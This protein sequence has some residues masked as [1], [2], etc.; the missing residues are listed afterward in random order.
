MNA[1]FV[2]AIA[3]INSGYSAFITGR[4]GTGKTTFI[5][6]IRENCRDRNFAVVA[7]TGIA[8]LNA[9][10]Q[11]IHSFFRLPFG[12]VDARDINVDPYRE[13]LYKRLDLL[14]IDEVSMVRADIL[15]GIDYVLRRSRKRKDVLFGGVQVI[16]VGDLFQLPPV[17]EQSLIKYFDISYGGPYFFMASCYQKFGGVQ[18]IEL[19]KIYRQSDSKFI[20]LLGR[21]CKNSMSDADLDIVNSRVIQL[22]SKEV[23]SDYIVL[24]TTN[25]I[26]EEVNQRFLRELKT[27]EFKYIAQVMG[28]FD[29]GSYPTD[30]DLI[31][32]QGAKVMFIRND[33]ERRWVNGTIGRISNLVDNRVF[34]VIGDTEHEV[35]KETWNKIDYDISYDKSKPGLAQ[36]VKG[37]FTQYPLRLAWAV[38]I[39]KG[40][41]KTFD[42]I[43]I[44][45]GNGMFAHGQAYVALSRARSLSGVVLKS[46]LRRRDVIF[47]KRIYGIVPGDSE[48]EELI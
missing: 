47:D 4:A 32:K 43:F 44:M 48:Y 28:V 40:Q 12:V 36:N 23:E 46:P 6:L 26:A 2:K 10:G 29:D 30:H 1:G 13:E 15:D 35:L 37:T 42:K 20:N 34:V 27:P 33:Q 17:V 41:G 14:I 5:D 11:T 9:K 3:L 7:P 25:K 31:L 45:P 38:T 39:H 24:S 19:T 8:A 22:V 16:L 21:M 18:T